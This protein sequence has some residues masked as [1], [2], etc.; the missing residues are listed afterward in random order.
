LLEWVY[1]SSLITGL[2]TGLAVGL[3]PGFDISARLLWQLGFVLLNLT[4]APN[5]V[6]VGGA[7]K[8]VRGALDVHGVSFLSSTTT[9]CHRRECTQALLEQPEEF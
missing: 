4:T 8:V 9:A 2:S 3:H 7:E 6:E 1:G 5:G